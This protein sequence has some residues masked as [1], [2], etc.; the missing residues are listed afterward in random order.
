MTFRIWL[1]FT[2][3]LTTSDAFEKTDSSIMSFKSSL[4]QIHDT[5]KKKPHNK[6]TAN[7]EL[8]AFLKDISNHKKKSFV[9]KKYY[10]AHKKHTSSQRIS[11]R[12]DT[13]LL[14]EKLAE[15]LTLYLNNSFDQ[16]AYTDTEGVT[17]SIKNPW[18]LFSLI[19]SNI[20]KHI[21]DTMVI[22]KSKNISFPTKDAQRIKDSYPAFKSS[23]LDVY[24]TNLGVGCEE[25][26]L[27]ILN[28]RNWSLI[29]LWMKFS[30]SVSTHSEKYLLME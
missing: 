26:K 25:Y 5:I 17:H 20:D 7:L 28:R 9:Y 15:M 27:Y 1:L 18:E 14:M 22:D 8:A 29:N 12:I 10:I 4:F 13:F 11:M 24:C 30:P 23:S 6:E 21:D 16:G 2:C 19:K 3:Q